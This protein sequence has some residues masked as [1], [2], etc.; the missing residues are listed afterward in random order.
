MVRLTSSCRI[1]PNTPR[2]SGNSSFNAFL[3]KLDQKFNHG[4]SY[5]VSYTLGKSIDEGSGTASGSDASGGAQIYAQSSSFKGPIRRADT[6][7]FHDLGGN[8]GN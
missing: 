7:A 2:H 3:A 1:V 6:A 4:L 8:V 5:L